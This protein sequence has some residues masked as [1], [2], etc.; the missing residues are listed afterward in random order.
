MF[1]LPAVDPAL[2]VADLPLHLGG[3]APSALH[4]AAGLGA[5]ARHGVLLYADRAIVGRHGQ[6]PADAARRLG[7]RREDPVLKFMV[8]GVTVYGMATFEGPMMS[9]QERQ[10]ALALHRLDHRARAP[11]RAGLER[12][13]DVRDALL[14]RA[15]HLRHDALL[16]TAR[17]RCTSGWRRS[18]SCSTSIP[19]YIAGVTQ[20]L[21]WREFTA[22]GVLRY[23]N[24]LE[25]VV[26]ILPMYCAAGGGR[27][28]LPAWARLSPPTTCTRPPRQGCS[29]AA[30]DAQAPPL[31]A[32][33]PAR[34]CDRPGIASLESRARRSSPCSRSWRW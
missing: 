14:D 18:A 7:S 8:V 28:A 20:G 26:R 30:E 4:G 10:C 11:G 3:A 13:P 22:D 1:S 5:D 9:H 34:R 21:M 19:I 12:R 24:F 23:P 29:S 2:L 25:T 27:H 15:A 6:R 33:T 17:Q 31:R 32:R 16:D